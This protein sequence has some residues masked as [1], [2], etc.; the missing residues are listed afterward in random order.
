MTRI[1]EEGYFLSAL[2][3][4]SAVRFRFSALEAGWRKNR[5]CKHRRLS[6]V[7]NAHP[8]SGMKVGI[9][10]PSNGW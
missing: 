8:V 10:I 7:G 2:S 5:G 3:V 9:T 6:E 4:Q 1:R